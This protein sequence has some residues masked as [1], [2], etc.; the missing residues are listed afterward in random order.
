MKP[1][2]VILA[3]G[4]GTRLYPVTME[5]PKP[6]L[7]VSK[8][9]IINYLVELFSKHNIEEII[10]S[11]LSEY[12]D[13]FFWWKKRYY[14]EKN[15]KLIAI[16]EPLGTWG[17][18]ARMKD[19]LKDSTFLV[20]NGDEIKEL[21]LSKMLDFHKKQ[22]VIASVAL[23]KVENPQNYGVA[24]L[25]GDL[26]KEFIEKP[27]NP[28]SQYI[29]SGLYFCEPEI[30]EYKKTPEFSDVE[31]DIFPFLA[32]EKKLAGFKFEGRWMDCGTWERYEDAIKELKKG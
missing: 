26:I 6:L 13:D 2:A 22:N 20:S 30:L 11:I 31:K 21:D 4:R 27:E 16:E 5:I 8:K 12:K 7:L 17:G 18:I 15:I 25:D 9:P 3:A 1:K 10:V 29:N 23:T 28:P 14:P 24:A 19:E 32:K